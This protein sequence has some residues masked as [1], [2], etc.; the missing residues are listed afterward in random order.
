[1][2]ARADVAIVV[3]LGSPTVS[4][5]ELGTLLGVSRRAL[6]RRLDAFGLR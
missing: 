6:Y 5:Q 3:D 1:M 2:A 4:E